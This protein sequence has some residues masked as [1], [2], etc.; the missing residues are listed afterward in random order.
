VTATWSASDRL[1]ALAAAEPGAPAVIGPG[2]VLTWTALDGVADAAAA[3]LVAAGRVG[4]GAVVAVETADVPW[5]IGA[6]VGVLRAGAVAAPL[7]AR[8]TAAERG[9]ALDVLAPAL[10]LAPSDPAPSGPGVRAIPPGA[11]A[12]FD[13]EDAAVVV[14]TSGTSGRPKGVVLSHRAM[15]AS[16]AAWMAVLPPACGWLLAVGLAHVAGLGIAWR[17]LEAG[18]PIRWVDP[19]D[20]A[21]ILTALTADPR[22]SHVSLVPSQ[23]ERVLEAAGG[24]PA[25]A[26]VRAVLLGGGPIPPDLVRRAVAVGWPIVTTYGLSEAGSGVSASTIADRDGTSGAAL[27]GVRL[28]IADPDVD[29]VGEIVVTTPAR[30]SCY[31]GEPRVGPDVPLR[32]GDLGR[33]DAHGRLTVVDRRTDRIVRGGEN[34]DPAEVEAVLGGHAA[35]ADAAVVGLPDPRLGH[36]P[37]AAVVPRAGAGV[38]DAAGLAAHVR[39]SLAPWKVPVAFRV[40]DAL[41]RTAG[42]KLRRDAVRALL[43][44][45]PAGELVR[46]D[47]ASIGWRITGRSTGDLTAE[48]ATPLILLPAS[49]STA[50]QLDRLAAALV[51]RA[52]LVRRGD[53]VVHAIDRRGAGSGRLGPGPA[54][55]LDIGVHVADLIAYLDARGLER[56]VLVGASYGAVLALEVAAR[57]PDRVTAV[58]AWEPPYAALA[59][60]ATRAAMAHLAQAVSTAHSERGPAAAAETFLRAVA[61]AAAWERLS[62]RAHEALAREGDAALS[63]AALLGLQPERLPAI[64][65]RTTILAGDRSAPFYATIAR[66][67]AAAIPG[68]TLRVLSGLDHPAPITQPAVVAEAI[69]ATLGR[70]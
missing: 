46:P 51:E 57:Q 68:A 67:L 19:A 20:G 16:V 9:R 58:V 43:G 7:P 12:T 24:A 2:A 44:G 26:R 32:T 54:R 1:R 4:S 65:A 70:P 60:P 15:A 66:A 63:D 23:L 45:A 47:G 3:R 53:V 61:G 5:A 33:L 56:V 17:A 11:A 48:S 18:V 29:G 8:L 42:G 6:I 31:L 41:P 64:S 13:P 59:D 52:D 34:I 55:P 22:L 28:E 49:L 62:P 40:L 35:I 39:V 37:V 50:A 25:P 38:P 21:A 36:V 27:P 30:C 69:R 10:V 14:L